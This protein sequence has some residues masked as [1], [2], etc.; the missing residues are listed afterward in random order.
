MVIG[1][2]VTGAGV[3]R[4]AA[5]NGLS[6]ALVER[7]DLASGTSSHSSHMLH[8]GLRYLEFGAFTLVR[9]SLEQRS[10]LARMAP[11]L[12]QP[13]RFMVPLFKGGRVSPLRLRAGLTLYDWLA[14]ARA[15]APH[16][17]LA[18][19]DALALEP[20]L[21]PRAL[22]AAALYSDVVMDDAR[23]VVI[24]KDV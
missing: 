12:A 5:R 20:G 16:V 19:R 21:E 1:G 15:L 22:R 9:E 10:E 7:G 6:V 11:A 24:R 13:R 18:P 8:G 23:L 17:M 3:A 14:G 4:L 2:G